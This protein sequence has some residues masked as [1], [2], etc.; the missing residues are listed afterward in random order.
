M[1]INDLSVAFQDRILL[2]KVSLAIGPGSLHVLMGPNGSGKSTLAA[3][4]MG[5]QRYQVTE[6]SITFNGQDITNLSPDKRARLGIFLAFQQPYELPGV[7]VFA[8]L[9]EAYQARTGKLIDVHEFKNLLHQAFAC[10]GLP[11]SFESR[12]VNE[13]F[14]G[15]EK[16]KLEVVQ[17]LILQPELVILDEIDSGLDS[18]ALNYVACAIAT[19]RAQ[20]PRT[21]FLVITHYHRIF[22]SLNPDR[23]HVLIDGACVQSGSAELAHAIE[24]DGYQTLRSAGL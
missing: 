16:K 21:A 11:T 4:L 2:K 23:V 13:G 19:M 18:D 9:K 22:A 8:F 24:R 5:H 17:M 3:T 20:N 12:S 10:V 15:G 14:S 1:L 6:G 7:S